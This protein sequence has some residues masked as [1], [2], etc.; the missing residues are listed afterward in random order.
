MGSYP[1]LETGAGHPVE[2]EL[3]LF[4]GI[5]NLCNGWVRFIIPRDPGTRFHFAPLQAPF[6]QQYTGGL[7]KGTDS[8]VLIRGSRIYTKSRAALEI[9]RRLSGIWP[10]MYLF[11]VIPGPVR[12]LVY[13]L[14]ARN[15]Y[16]WFGKREHC[17]LPDDA[18]RA[19]FM[20]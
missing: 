8:V 11:M 10:I 5:C 16:S 7:P 17:M 15:R 12:D 3:I 13:D 1:L 2:N 20:E 19:R 6:A 18:I 14:I 4:D 9:F